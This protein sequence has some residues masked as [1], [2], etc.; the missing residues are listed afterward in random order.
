MCSTDI[1][2]SRLLSA[3][4]AALSFVRRLQDR[5]QIGVIA[6]SGF[7][8]LIQAPTTKPELL[9]NAIESLTLVST[10]AVGSGILKSLEAIAI[11]HPDLVPAMVQQSSDMPVFGQRVLAPEGAYVPAIII[12]LTDGVSNTGPD[13]L[14]VAQLAA[15]RGVRVFTIGFGTA[16]GALYP[17]CPQQDQGNQPNEGVPFIMQFGGEAHGTS[18]EFRD[19][20]IHF[21]RYSGDGGNGGAGSGFPRGIDEATL[22][23][24]ATMT[25]GTYY[26]AESASELEKVYK[27]LSTQLITQQARSELSVAFAAIGA[28][29]AAMAVMLSM[30]WNPLG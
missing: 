10:T 9:Q 21:R 4:A 19:N 1:K 26:P 30:L 25:D 15:D 28:F 29:L 20:E 6:F 27:E 23:Q 12:L 8:E 14:E 2:P 13:P 7:T 24:I 11:T 16:D 22:E 18:A 5:N 3:E 17:E